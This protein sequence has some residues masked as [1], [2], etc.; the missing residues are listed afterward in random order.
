MKKRGLRLLVILMAL[1]SISLVQ[2]DDPPEVIDIDL[3]DFDIE[4]HLTVVGG[5]VRHVA[6]G[7][8]VEGV[9]LK[10][11]CERDGDVNKISFFGLESADDG[12]YTAWT[13]NYFTSRECEP[14]DLVWVE[15]KYEGETYS[16]E[17]VEVKRLTP[18]YDFA[19]ADVAV[20]VPEF[21]TASLAAAATISGLG[22]ALLRRK[23]S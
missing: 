15:A 8:P 16:S 22:I 19:D 13:F 3:D 6:T 2:A 12:Q 20:G 18:F 9:P 23:K 4:G 1:L 21:G 11:Y 10:V 7:E 17:K 14:G 5:T